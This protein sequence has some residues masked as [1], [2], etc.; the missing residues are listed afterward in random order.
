MLNVT[1]NIREKLLIIA[2]IINNLIIT[3]QSLNL[4]II[5]YP[6]FVIVFKK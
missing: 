6:I 3:F 5:K 4:V 1:N 2:K